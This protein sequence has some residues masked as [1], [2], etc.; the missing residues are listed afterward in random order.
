MTVDSS[1][2]KQIAMVIGAAFFPVRALCL[3]SYNWRTR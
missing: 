3:K 2:E 1:G